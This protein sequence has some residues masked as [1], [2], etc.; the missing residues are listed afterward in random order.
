MTELPASSALRASKSRS[1]DRL[2]CCWRTSSTTEATENVNATPP[3]AAILHTAT[4]KEQREEESAVAGSPES[5]YNCRTTLKPLFRH[6]HSESDIIR[7][8]Y[9]QLKWLGWVGLK[10]DDSDGEFVKKETMMSI[11]EKVGGGM[12]NKL[13]NKT[14]EMK[15]N[16]FLAKS[17]DSK[18]GKRIENRES[19]L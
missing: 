8:L 13:I 16:G 19:L 2:P 11:K 17:I 3:S 7:M 5:N 14:Q 9:E 18:R 6:S 1:R 10:S 15:R 12:V 4:E